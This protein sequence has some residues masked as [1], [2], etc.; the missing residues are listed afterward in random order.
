[1]LDAES[2]KDDMLVFVIPTPPPAGKV[3]PHIP[4][5]S[6]LIRLVGNGHIVLHLLQRDPI[7][8]EEPLS[9]DIRYNKAAF[10]TID[11][12]VINSDLPV[13]RHD[14]LL[15]AEIRCFIE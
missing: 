13:N 10:C 15:Q 4:F 11:I 6:P 7:A 5:P 1:M 9:S 2:L 14:S 8:V 12:I 3:L